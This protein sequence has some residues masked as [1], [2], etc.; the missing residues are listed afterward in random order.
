MKLLILSAKTG[1]GHEMRAK[2]LEEISD[3]M[4]FESLI[5]RPLRLI[6]FFAKDKILTGSPMSRRKIS[7]PLA[8]ADDWITR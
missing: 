7:P 1:G 2:A 6:I 3:A 5:L 4:G 8:N